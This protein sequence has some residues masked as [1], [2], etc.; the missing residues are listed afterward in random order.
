MV[1][2]GYA[3]KAGN[4]KKR[5]FAT[6]SFGPWGFP[7]NQGCPFGGPHNIDS[8]ILVFMGLYWGPPHIWVN[9]QMNS[10]M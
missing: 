1:R 2:S 5:N 8:G 10:T 7:Q 6:V 4:Q 3:K 9:Y